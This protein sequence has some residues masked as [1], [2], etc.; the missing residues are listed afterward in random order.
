MEMDWVNSLMDETTN[1]F[2]INAFDGELLTEKSEET[3]L[4]KNKIIQPDLKKDIVKI[5][6][7]HLQ[8]EDKQEQNQNISAAKKVEQGIDDIQNRIDRLIDCIA[9]EKDDSLREDYKNRIARLKTQQQ[10]LK[11]NLTEIKNVS[12]EESKLTLSKILTLLKHAKDIFNGSNLEEKSEFLK[13]ISSNFSLKGKT[14][15][16]FYKNLIQLLSKSDPCL[17]ILRQ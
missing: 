12:T 6:V 1:V 15:S 8:K 13:I 9:D 5:A 2:V 7:D 11:S 4:V 10:E 17:N 14:V 16:F 3:L